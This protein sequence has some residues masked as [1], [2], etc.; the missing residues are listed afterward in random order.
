MTGE[1]VLLKG[2]GRLLPVVVNGRLIGRVIMEESDNTKNKYF[3]NLS[4]EE[5]SKEIKELSKEIKFKYNYAPWIITL[6]VIFAIVT[7]FSV[8]ISESFNK[9][10][11]VLY[12]SN[13]VINLPPDW[14]IITG[15][16]IGFFLSIGGEEAIAEK[17]YL[18][19]NGQG[20]YFY[21]SIG[22]LLLKDEVTSLIKEF[23]EG[24][25]FVVKYNSTKWLP[26]EARLEGYQIYIAMEGDRLYTAA[27]NTGDDSIIA[28]LNIKPFGFFKGFFDGFLLPFQAVGSIFTDSLHPVKTA[29]N[30]GSYYLGFIIGIILLVVIVKKIISQFRNDITNQK[31]KSE[32]MKRKRRA[33]VERRKKE[34]AKRDWEKKWA[35]MSIDEKVAYKTQQHL[36]VQ[37]QNTQNVEKLSKECIGWAMKFKNKSPDAALAE[38]NRDN[39]KGLSDKVGGFLSDVFTAGESGLDDAKKHYKKLANIYKYYEARYNISLGNLT[40]VNSEYNFIREKA[41]L[42]MQKI[43][44]II[45]ELRLKDRQVFDKLEGVKFDQGL[46][47]DKE[48]QSIFRSIA[49]FNANYRKQA[50]ES[51]NNS[52]ETAI[53]VGGIFKDTNLNKQTKKNKGDFS[54][55]DMVLAGIGLAA[56][57]AV[58]AVEGVSQYFGSMSAKKEA[59]TR[60]AGREL[61]LRQAIEDIEKTNRP[62]VENLIKRETELNYSLNESMERYVTVFNNV[63]SYI[64][65]ANDNSK[66]KEARQKRKDDGGEYFTAD[67]FLKIKEL[68]EFRKFLGMLVDADL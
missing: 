16:A 28:K 19:S 15:E 13:V 59:K 51:F 67:E 62:K 7:F 37:K 57:A 32:N 21:L 54:D 49:Q 11:L 25:K 48:I 34:I 14:S 18:F 8:S 58:M 9:N 26:I 20:L 10:D 2:R 60:L 63:N 30:G 23:K 56:G 65:P 53:T 52:M 41:I 45:A 40:V 22:G 24:E 61:K 50:E 36:E 66:T 35:A 17:Q 44:E 43:N 38:F 33:E 68:R 64:F 39:S 47:G 27:T 6:A 31:K 42:Y 46:L 4:D 1:I 12:D 55:G 29:N 3:S 5:L